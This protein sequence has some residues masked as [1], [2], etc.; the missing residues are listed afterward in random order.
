MARVLLVAV[1]ATLVFVAAGPALAQTVPD[2]TSLGDAAET[3][4]TAVAGILVAVL[5]FGL[6]LKFIKSGAKKIGF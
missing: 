2:M 3:V 5:A 1:V 6:A 4:Y